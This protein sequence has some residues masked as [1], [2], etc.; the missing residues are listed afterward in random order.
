MEGV[1]KNDSQIR[2]MAPESLHLEDSVIRD[3]QL[4]L[5]VGGYRNPSSNP[6]LVHDACM[7]N[8]HVMLQTLIHINFN[9]PNPSY[10]KPPTTPPIY[11]KKTLTS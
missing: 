9:I 4:L 11:T 10:L 2:G 7:Q 6:A 1:E 8:L 3:I 5:R